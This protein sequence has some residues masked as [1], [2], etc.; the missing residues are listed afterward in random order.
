[1]LG[2]PRRSGVLQPLDLRGITTMAINTTSSA[3]TPQAK[4]DT[5]YYEEDD[6]AAGSTVQLDVMA[7][8]LGG[9]AKVL[10]SVEDDYGNTLDPAELQGFVTKDADTLSDFSTWDTTTYGNQVGIVGG[11]LYYHVTT[12]GAATIN[13]LDDGEVLQ[14]TF[15][16]AIRMA[17]GTLSIAKVTVTITGAD[18]A[19]TLADPTDGAIAE[20]DQSAAT[21]D[22]GLS[23]TLV[24]AD[25]DA[26]DTLTYGI[27][28]GTANGD[29]TVSRVGTYGTLTVDTS[30]G[31]YSYAKDAAAIE[32]LD[33]GDTPTDSFTVSV[34][35][36]DGPL[37]TQTYEVHLSGADD[38][39]TLADPTDGAIAEVDQS[40]ATTDAGLSGTLV[41]ADV[42]AG[43]TLTYGIV[44][45]T[46]NGDGTVSR[47]GTYGTLTV[48]TSTGAYS[49]AKDAAAIEALDAGDTPTDSFTV[50]VSDGDGPLVTQT[51]EVHLSG[52]DDAPVITAPNGGNA[53]TVTFAE[54]TALGTV[55]ANVDATDVDSPLLTY[56]ITG[57]NEAGRFAIDSATGVITLAAALD[58]E[59][60]TSYT[61]AIQ[62]SDGSLADTQ[63]IV[64]NVTDVVE[65]AAPVARDDVWVLSNTA[66]AAGVITAD[67]F[68]HN[69]TDADGD[70][71]YVTAVSGLPAGLTANFDGAGHLVDI[72]GTAAAGSYS[73][74]YTLSDGTTT[75]SAF[76]SL[77][78][79]TTS[80]TANSISLDG[81]DF[82][83]LD[84][85]SGDD[86]ATGD[87]ALAGNA[88]RD[89]FIGANGN[90][91]LSGGAGDDNLLG[92][93]NGDFLNGGDGNDVLDGG[94][95]N[96]TLVGGAGLDI[97]TGGNNNDVFRWDS[98]ADFGDTLLDFGNGDD[99][100][101]FDVG[102][103]GTQIS[104]G[105]NDTTT[106]YAEGA[107]K[108]AAGMNVAGN[109]VVV[110]FSEVLDGGDAGSDAN[111]EVQAAIDGYTNITTGALFVFD[112]GSSAQVW[113]DA[114]PSVAGGAVLVAN[115]SN[116]S[117]INSATFAPGDFNFV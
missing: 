21:T 41:G 114:N 54:N 111:A 95:G 24:G 7:N 40:A 6:F 101:R 2:A 17:N 30:T 105:N 16:Y 94:A 84:L 75:D 57:G 109:E 100:L 27:V 64:V 60:T 39:P 43:D 63:Q 66:I 98:T 56:S 72:T 1:M 42:D 110:Q 46:A 20:V 93:A 13:A 12:A 82:S 103:T 32:A 76:A 35:D 88:G 37:V 45:G 90:D 33:A 4:D 102:T 80:A 10:W 116:I 86:L 87:M 31:A 107:D 97:L 70:P 36:G 59:T 49:Y 91:T 92:G 51:Y 28:G 25:V 81:N 38:A 5:F 53:H 8:D 26:G 112:V 47:V 65:N 108:N 113:Y 78:V 67:W 79:L 11:K 62:V 15:S 99:T 44:G 96:D 19:P 61:L 71:L 74:T 117:T 9:K 104:I 3:N 85:L 106:T 18:D 22:A 77:A 29:G 73:L 68:T 52:A 14:D 23:G 115:L 48:D 34:S 69:D 50:S 89:T 55:I 83:Y 58:Y